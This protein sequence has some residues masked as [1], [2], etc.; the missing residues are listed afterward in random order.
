VVGGWSSTHSTRGL[1]PSTAH[2]LHVAHVCYTRLCKQT[3]LAPWHS[4]APRSTTRAHTRTHARTT[5]GG[6]GRWRAGGQQGRQV[7]GC[8]RCALPDREAHA[9]A[10]AAVPDA[11]QGARRGVRACVCLCGGKGELCVLWLGVGLGGACGLAEL[12]RCACKLTPRPHAH[13]P[14][15]HSITHKNTLVRPPPPP[16][17]HTHAHTRTHTP[18]RAH[19][20]TCSSSSRTT[21]PRPPT[22]SR[23]SS[24]RWQRRASA[25]SPAAPSPCASSG[26]VCKPCACCVCLGRVRGGGAC[27]CACLWALRARAC[28][29]P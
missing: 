6:Q 28:R 16:H 21:T 7:P 19:S 20:A 1:G 14:P 29:S 27:P 2:V 18:L 17:T 25:T 13:T 5:P 24:T 10:G 15:V 8:G 4:L 23:P 26:F 22:T 3:P 9:H 11:G 12:W